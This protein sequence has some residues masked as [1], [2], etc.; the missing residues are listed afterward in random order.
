MEQG[1]EFLFLHS[2][3]EN[4]YRCA[5][6]LGEGL[7]FAWFKYRKSISLMDSGFSSPR[8]PGQIVSQII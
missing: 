2:G 4:I 1:S 3:E 5:K 6:Y 7:T 8:I